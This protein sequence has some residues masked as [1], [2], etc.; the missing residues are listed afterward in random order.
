[1]NTKQAKKAVERRL[2]ESVAG[3]MNATGGT[4][5]CAE[6]TEQ[7]PPDCVLKS[8][9]GKF[10]TREVEV[11][12]IPANHVLRE[13][14][15]NA[16]RC[17]GA[18]KVE[19]R[20]KGIEGY[21]ISFTLTDEG[22]RYGVQ[23]SQVKRLAGIVCNGIFAGRAELNGVEIWKSAPDIVDR[24]DS[25]GWAPLSTLKELNVHP[26]FGGW[27]QP[28]GC[29]WIGDAIREKSAA[30]GERA[31]CWDLVIGG[32]WQ[33][34]A[35]SVEAYMRDDIVRPSPFRSIWVTT[36]FDGVFRIQ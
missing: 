7:D 2:C 6:S 16:W 12:S 18:L 14:N 22:S 36:A 20:G 21:D 3:E 8:R 28:E 23:P 34:G 1:M 19:L 27:P 35:D 31:K 17:A 24:L 32:T 4:D 29:T 30:Y 13:D 15:G 26:T 5:Y 11:T 9:S 25:I 10:Q 33:V